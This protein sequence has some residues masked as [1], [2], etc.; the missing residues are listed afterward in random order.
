MKHETLTKKE[1]QTNKEHHWRLSNGGRAKD[2]MHKFLDSRLLTSC[3]WN[4]SVLGIVG[5]R[6]NNKQ[7]TNDF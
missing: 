4:F 2:V 7:V 1:L 3:E 6:D 5:P